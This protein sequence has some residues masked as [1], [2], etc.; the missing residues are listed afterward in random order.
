MKILQINCVY[1]LG[2]TG[3]IVH[4]IHKELLRRSEQSI[5]CYGRGKY[6]QEQYIYKTCGELYSKCNNLLSRFTGIMYGG[7]FFSTRKLIYI[8][9]RE[10]PDIVHLHCIN[11]Y[12]VNIY[13]LITWLKNNHIKVVLT[14]HAEF[15]YTANC[16]YALDCNQWLCGCG[17][18]PRLYDATKSLFI[19][20]THASWKKMYQAFS[21]FDQ[22]L[23]V[24]SVSPWLMERAKKSTILRNKRHY[25]IYNGVD[26]NTFRYRSNQSILAKY[27][28]PHG[29]KICFCP[30]AYFS[31]DK[32][33]LKG[34]YYVY[35]LAQLMQ[36]DDVLFVV[37]GNHD[38]D[39]YKQNN[40]LFLG[41][42]SNQMDLAALYAISDVTLLTSKRETFSMVC[43]ES[44]CCGTPVVGF[45]SGGPEQISIPEY[46]HFVKYGDVLKLKLEITQILNQFIDKNNISQI[47]TMF[48]STKSMVNKYYKIYKKLKYMK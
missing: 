36:H 16:G 45:E 12:F 2:S 8:I 14:L 3:K 35:Q 47:S 42:I 19:D 34:G 20:N 4:E 22:N 6:L 46:S 29:K 25:V 9:L 26:V 33:H 37:A 17:H 1:P 24:I 5:V 11:G 32:N 15:M 30:T 48:Y 43:A 31:F 10:N 41:Y 38:K 27:H 44:L 23:V 28:I 18:C 7:C 21:G 13:Y 40:L 39:I